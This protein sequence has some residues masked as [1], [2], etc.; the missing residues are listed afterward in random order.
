MKLLDEERILVGQYPEG[1]ADGPQIEAN[2]EYILN[3]FVTAYGNPFEIIR[4]PMPPE[5][6]AFPN[7]NGD[8]RTY[9]NA[10]FLNKPSWCPPTRNNL[11]P[12]GSESGKRRCLV[13][14]S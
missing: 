10:I 5:N 14:T 3:N 8:Y 1:I 11:T 12:Q 9:A 4:V 6:G 2:I 13:I 7:T